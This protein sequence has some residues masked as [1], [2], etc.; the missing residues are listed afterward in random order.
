MPSRRNSGFT[1]TPKPSPYF[2]PERRSSAG[3][4]DLVRRAR[5]HRAADDDDVVAGFVARAPRRSA[6]R[7]ARGTSGRGC[8]SCG[9]ACRRRRATGRWRAPPPPCRW[10]R[11]AGPAATASRDQLV[12][13]RL[14]DR[15]AARVD[16]R[17]LVRHS[18]RR[19][20]TVVP[21]RGERRRRHAAR[22]SPART[23]K[24]S[25]PL[26]C[27]SLPESELRRS[28]PREPSH[29][30]T[31]VNRVRSPGCVTPSAA[32]TVRAPLRNRRPPPTSRND[33][34]RAGAPP[35]RAAP[36]RPRRAA[37]CTTACANRPARR[38]AAR[39]SPDVDRQPLGAD[40]RRDHRLAHAPSP[41]KSSGACR[42]RCAAARRRPR[43]RRHVRPHVVH[44]A[45]D[46]DA[47]RRSARRL[48]RRRR[49]AADDR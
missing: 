5:Q 17:D 6:R 40:R 29:W 19:P 31:A 37:G 36:R 1:D 39:C 20:T 13:A 7:R 28:D 25:Y 41:R 2:L 8:R 34:P 22:H 32:R 15:A 23:L 35:A 18:R 46:L 10:S 30:R 3:I 12:E 11:A 48:H 14:D 4:T 21:V 38:R 49:R 26:T 47:V 9:S 42:R 45:G 16:A 24:P 33:R 43:P 27:D 44:A